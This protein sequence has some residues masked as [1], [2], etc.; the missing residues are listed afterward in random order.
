MPINGPEIVFGYN[1]SVVN[2]VSI[3]KSNISKK[4][5]GIW[6]HAVREASTAGIYKLGFGKG[7]NN[8]SYW[9]TN[10]FSG[11]DKEKEAEKWMWLKYPGAR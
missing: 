11:T 9:L 4:H 10:N 1:M 2:A 5:L 7:T 6:Y 8:N 3:L